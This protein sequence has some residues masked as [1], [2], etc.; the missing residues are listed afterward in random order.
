[1]RQR[2]IDC[3]WFVALA[4]I[5]GLGFCSCRRQVAVPAVNQGTSQSAAP[6]PPHSRQL[7][8]VGADQQKSCGKFVQ[9][10]YDWYINGRLKGLNGPDWSDVRDRKPPVLS[11]ELSRL[12]EREQASDEVAGDIGAIDFD[13]FIAAQDWDGPFVVKDV[14]VTGTRCRAKVF[15]YWKGKLKSRENVEPELEFSDRK[16]LFIN[17][18]YRYYSE[19]GKTKLFPSNDLLHILLR[20]EKESKPKGKGVRD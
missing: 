17:F 8:Q 7:T 19:D 5:G 18:H 15:G 16:W 6:V 9:G 10:F 20:A 2:E 3:G 13:P 12:L 4:L 1:M 11:A 14:S